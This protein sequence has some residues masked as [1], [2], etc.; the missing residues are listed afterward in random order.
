MPIVEYQ[1]T[2]KTYAALFHTGQSL[3]RMAEKS[4]EGRLL[5]LQA[6]KVFSFFSLEAYLNHVGD[7]EIEKW[8]DYDRSPFNQKFKLV[9]QA[10]HT[11]ALLDGVLLEHI[12][13]LRVFRNDMAHG[14]TMVKTETVATK[15]EP[16][17]NDMWKI[18]SHETITIQD[19]QKDYSVVK[20]V[21][22]LFNSKRHRPD[23]LFLNQGI[24]SYSMS[25]EDV[26]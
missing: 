15:D 7:N 6:A 8:N 3:L 1:Y 18:F 10:L 4:E 16:N 21:I 20:K 25:M 14:N 26:K 23:P 22:E 12:S 9:S 13:S 11:E 19:V 24:R 5:L 2:C 17:F